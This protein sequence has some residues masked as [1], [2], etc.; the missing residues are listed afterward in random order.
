MSA[1]NAAASGGPDGSGALTGVTTTVP[2]AEAAEFGRL[3]I[4]VSN[5]KPEKNSLCDRRKHRL[6]FMFVGKQKEKTKSTR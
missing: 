3:A 5:S 4:K 6:Q 1:S 2:R